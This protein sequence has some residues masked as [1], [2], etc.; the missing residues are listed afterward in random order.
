M[1]RAYFPPL[2]FKELQQPTQS[3]HTCIIILMKIHLNAQKVLVSLDIEYNSTMFLLSS[4]ILCYIVPNQLNVG[5]RA[6]TGV[7]SPPL[8]LAVLVVIQTKYH[9][10]YFHLK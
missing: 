9:G 2:T 7:H 10:L 4:N 6:F 3:S 1:Y 8:H 5:I